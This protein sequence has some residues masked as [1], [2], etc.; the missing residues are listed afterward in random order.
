MNRNPYD[1]INDLFRWQGPSVDE[2]RD[3]EYRQA[4]ERLAAMAEQDNLRPPRFGE[5]EYQRGFMDRAFSMFNA[6]QQFLFKLTQEV[7]Q[8]GF[9]AGDIWKALSHGANYFNPFSDAKYIDADEIRQIFTGPSAEGVKRTFSEGAANLAISIFY[10]PTWLIPFVGLAAKGGQISGRTANIM[11]RTLNPGI[12]ALD[13]AK[14]G[15]QQTGRAGEA[16]LA[17]A[18]GAERSSEITN[19]IKRWVTDRHAGIDEGAKELLNKMQYQIFGHAREAGRY[20][21]EMNKLTPEGQVL[22]ARMLE[23]DSVRTARE[24]FGERL[25]KTS[26]EFM[27]SMTVAAGG[28][29]QRQADEF[30]TLL[31]EAER[32]GIDKNLLWE[33]YDKVQRVTMGL[34]EDLLRL[35]VIPAEAAAEYKGVYLRRL[36]TATD[37]PRAAFDRIQTLLRAA[38]ADPTS[39][40]GVQVNRYLDDMQVFD[41]IAFRRNLPKAA[42]KIEGLGI[43][44]VPLSPSAITDEAVSGSVGLQRM[45]ERSIL[46][47]LPEGID[48][49]PINKITG[50]RTL[51][52]DAFIESIGEYSRANPLAT[53]DDL[54]GHVQST[55]Y[56]GQR[57][58]AALTELVAQ[59]VTD[60]MTTQM[61][62]RGWATQFSDW[63]AQ[64]STSFRQYGIQFQKIAERE[65]IPEFIRREVLGEI[66]SVL[67]RLAATAEVSGRQLE[68]SRLFDAFSGGRRITDETYQAVRT[69][70]SEG[71]PI[72]EKIRQELVEAY[73]EDGL[74]AAVQGI[75]RGSEGFSVGS[76]VVPSRGSRWASIEKNEVHR[77]HLLGEEFGS[78]HDMYVTPGLAAVLT[79]YKKLHQKALGESPETALTKLGDAAATFTNFFKF[80]KIIMD[81]A[82][83]VRDTVSSIIQ[84]EMTTGLPFRAGNFKKSVQAASEFMAGRESVYHRAAGLI[85]YDLGG[86]G[87]FNSELQQLARELAGVSFRST[88]R[89]GTWWDNAVDLFTPVNKALSKVKDA[90]SAQYQFRENVFRTYVFS[91]TY[92]DLAEKAARLG[93][94]VTSREFMERAARQA[95]A[96][97]DRALFNYADVPLAVEFARKYGIAPF[98]TFPYKAAPQLFHVMHEA[99]YRVLK[100]ERGV[101][102]WNNNWAGGSEA[103]A[104]EIAALP[105]Y[106][107][108]AMVV[109]LPFPDK[110]NNPLY[111]D[112]S[113]FLPWYV[114]NDIAKDARAT[115]DSLRGVEGNLEDNRRRILGEGGARG[116]IFSPIWAQLNEAF[117]NNKDGLGRPIYKA[118]DTTEQK[119]F[120]LGKYLYQFLAPPT[121]PGGS[122]SDTVGRAFQAVASTSPEPIDWMNTLGRSMRTMGFAQDPAD[123][124]NRYNER[125]ISRALGGGGAN[126]QALGNM[127][128]M[129]LIAPPTPESNENPTLQLLGGL[130]NLFVNVTASDSRRQTRNEITERTLTNTEIQRQIAIVRTNRNMSAEDRREEIRRLQDII[131]ENNLLSRENILRM[132]P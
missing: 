120:E 125:P 66:E 31:R 25:P 106:K 65:A 55:I 35:G 98:L 9:Q 32:L 118:T 37:N 102:Q 89:Q 44:R 60:S 64:T 19:S 84:I 94:D 26:S 33:S 61:G 54:L 112:L 16:L 46:G 131:R 109:R 4:S 7:S 126:L 8:D 28:M 57:V 90:A 111:L 14:V 69:A 11:N 107:R 123:A 122:T 63:S 103:V 24:I 49:F 41:R 108:D 83:N 127:A 67:P 68:M 96:L 62:L 13:A 47:P 78:L 70:A 117:V 71:T 22:L 99:P 6:P 43:G 50:K 113:Y 38:E 110:D 82:A 10:D 74:A 81:P 59:A 48:Y 73:G 104:A 21:K 23:S 92:D 91:S 121:F 42:E 40:I 18:V 30:G 88:N 93:T 17:S 105:D 27:P 36:Y 12:L 53:V 56:A 75:L 97:T 39:P 128:T 114:I 80:S 79:N 116:G 130:A 5:P 129:G 85:G 72:P 95:S 51:D 76:L 58:P 119:I 100:Y 86:A 2:W 20:I 87:F 1:N 115:V 3:Q 132:R 45:G 77:V 15:A 52:T 29:T 101:T 124:V 34:T